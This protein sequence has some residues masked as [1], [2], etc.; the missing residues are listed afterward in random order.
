MKYHLRHNMLRYI[1]IT[2]LFSL[3]TIGIIATIIVAIKKPHSTWVPMLIVLL[4]IAFI[5]YL[6]FWHN[7]R[8]T[9][10]F[11]R[12]YE[13]ISEQPS[14]DRAL[15]NILFNDS[16]LQQV[17]PE[18]QPLAQLLQSDYRPTV[19][20]A[21]DVEIIISGQRKLEALL[22]DLQNAKRYIYMEYF[23]FG[24][25]SGSRKVRDMLIQKAKEGVEVR[26]INENIA[27]F[28]IPYAYFNAMKLAGIEVI[29]FTDVGDHL[30]DMLLHVNYRDHRKIVVIDGEIGYIGGM[31][32]NNHY[33]YQWR[34]THI[35]LTGAA[36]GQLEY[37]FLDSW[38]TSGGKCDIPLTPYADTHE[39]ALVQITPD[40][41][42]AAEPII[43]RGYEWACNHAQQYIYM[44]TPY[45]VPP[46]SFLQAMKNAA[47]RG[48]DV[49]LM[50]PAKPDSW[51][52]R[53]V[54]KS[55]YKE[56]LQA[57]VRI[58]ERGGEFMHSKTF[59]M[60]D[61]V[62]QIGSANLDYRSLELDYEANCY[63]YDTEI[64]LQNKT[65]FTNDY[66]ISHEVTLS[67]V[68]AWSWYQILWQRFM[69]LFKHM[70]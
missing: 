65:I 58:F 30:F 9:K 13:Q 53:P 61:Y 14:T 23:H 32:I 38:L 18:Y 20:T 67:E 16:C 49:Q 40:A 28:P 7:L 19:T 22:A 8:N 69:R 2:I 48:I 41:P 43:L 64:A 52:L 29:H 12:S 10:H 70:L 66:A 25:D 3:V 47:Q 63:I 15:Q 50:V 26:F 56:L 68:Q 54:N 37:C 60:D 45:L 24:V 46:K 34:D 55:Y 33:F 31:N 27:N 4:I 11:H 6:F 1:Y 57:G 59:V 42:D 39:G 62:S 35:R 21:Q 51:M 44:Q 5:L 36:V 17:R